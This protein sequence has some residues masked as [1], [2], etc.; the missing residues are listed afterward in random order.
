MGVNEILFRQYLDTVTILNEENLSQVCV[1]CHREHD[2]QNSK[3]TSNVL[4]KWQ[5]AIVFNTLLRRET[6]T[7]ESKW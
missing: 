3:R 5:T 4:A 1:P 2:V 6:V 7:K